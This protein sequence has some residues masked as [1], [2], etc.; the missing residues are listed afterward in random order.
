MKKL[1]ICLVPVALMAANVSA[2]PPS[3]W[4]GIAAGDLG[5]LTRASDDANMVLVQYRRGG[6]GAYVNRAN[7]NRASVNR[8][9][10]N[11][12][13]FHRDV[14]VNRNVNVNRNVSVN[15]G[16]GGGYYG[17]GSY[18][19]NW[20]GVAAGV[21]VGAGVTAM[22]TS[23]ARR[24]TFGLRIADSYNASAPRSQRTG[25]FRPNDHAPGAAPGGPATNCF[26]RS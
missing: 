26:A 19:P 18:G 22:A 17:G 15:R 9:S 25:A 1:L 3:G 20:G 4:A 11:S 8:S 23:A 24:N 14:S 13:N 5:A 12:A 2:A 10:F 16:Y 6:G 21:A 7:V